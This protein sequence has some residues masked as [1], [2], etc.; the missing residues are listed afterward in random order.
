MTQSGVV[1][2]T[3]EYMAPEQLH[4]DTAE[5]TDV[6]ALGLIAYD[7]LLARHRLEGVDQPM[8]EAVSRS[9]RPLPAVSS[10]RPEVP[11]HLAAIVD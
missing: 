5:R 11:S 6:Y 9:Q 7:M 2:G 10:R 3:L 1:V 8:L 4:G